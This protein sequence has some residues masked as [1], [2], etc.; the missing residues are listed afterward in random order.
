MLTVLIAAVAARRAPLWKLFALATAG[1]M[2]IVP[3]VYR[4][5]GTFLLLPLWCGMFLSSRRATRLA[6]ATLYSPLPLLVS[7][8]PPFHAIYPALLVIFFLAV[9]TDPAQEE[10][11][12]AEGDLIGASGSNR[13][14]DGPAR[15]MAVRGDSA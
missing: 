11:P 2:L 10:S 14:A 7:L 12:P 8:R 5:D 13:A 1:S 15:S 9:A 6:S 4:Y 3:H